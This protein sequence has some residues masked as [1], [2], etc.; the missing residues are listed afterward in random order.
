[1]ALNMDEQGTSPIVLNDDERR[2]LEAAWLQS[3][4]GDVASEDEV[5]AAYGS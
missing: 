3:E 5:K 2:A 4:A 1:M